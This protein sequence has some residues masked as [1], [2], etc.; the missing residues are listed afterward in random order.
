MDQFL[1]RFNNHLSQPCIARLSY[2]TSRYEQASAEDHGA[3]LSHDA[4]FANVPFLW[5]LQKVC[6]QIIGAPTGWPESHHEQ[7]YSA[8]M[9]IPPPAQEACLSTMLAKHT[10]LTKA[11]RLRIDS[12]HDF[13]QLITNRYRQIRGIPEA[14]A[15]SHS[16]C[17]A[18]SI[19]FQSSKS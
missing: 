17:S 3:L 2:I 7:R 6:H 11:L 16:S 15:I 4:P 13:Q 18:G 12:W 10:D 14:I 9:L 8:T 1:A 19:G 5:L